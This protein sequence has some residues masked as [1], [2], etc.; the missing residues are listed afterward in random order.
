MRTRLEQQIALED[1]VRGM[2]TTRFPAIDP[3]W[4]VKHHMDTLYRISREVASVLL[5][6][7]PEVL[8]VMREASK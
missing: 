4:A 1:L 7:R 6:M 8:R 5:A 2:V 3:D